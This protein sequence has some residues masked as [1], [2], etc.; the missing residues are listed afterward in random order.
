MKKKIFSMMMAV[1]VGCTT[2]FGGAASVYADEKTIEDS[3]ADASEVTPGDEI[4][5]T[6]SDTTVD[7]N[8]YKDEVVYSVV[9][10]TG[11][12]KFTYDYGAVWNPSTHKYELGDSKKPEGGWLESD[13][14]GSN[15]KISIAN[16]SNYP[17]TA[18]LTYANNGGLSNVSSVDDP[19]TGHFYD[20]AKCTDNEAASKKI[21]IDM[22]YDNCTTTGLKYWKIP[23]GQTNAKKSSVD[24]FF[25]YTGTPK[26]IDSENKTITSAGTISIKL[27]PYANPEAVTVK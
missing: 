18:S 2:L 23:N 21:D 6:S 12:L 14:N 24:V 1:A 5:S 25:A 4:G 7:L 8:H 20:N 3:N 9:I 19:I 13:K 17:I 10:T 26:G 15:N 22:N 16:N 27:S 11:A